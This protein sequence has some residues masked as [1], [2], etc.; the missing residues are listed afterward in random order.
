MA[1]LVATLLLLASCGLARADVVLQWADIGL[2]AARSS[3]P[4]SAHATRALAGMHMA[5]LEAMNFIEGRYV[6]RFS[7]RLRI[8]LGVSSEAAGVAAAHRYLTLIYP[9]QSDALN[10]ALDESLR[11]MPGFESTSSAVVIGRTIGETVYALWRRHIASETG[12]GADLLDS[13]A[14]AAKLVEARGLT[15]IESARLLA[16]VAIALGDMAPE[17]TRTAAATT[18]AIVQP[19]R[20]QQR[21]PA[22]DQALKYYLP[23]R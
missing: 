3:Q 8:P 23:T 19:S 11:R 13:Y 5:M 4:Q 15:P 14:T 21:Q 22:A 2:A 16:L 12:Q 1:R 20:S 17:A 6:P 18:L 10:Q 9:S 7:V